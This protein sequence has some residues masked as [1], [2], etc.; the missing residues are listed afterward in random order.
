M[1]KTLEIGPNFATCVHSSQLTIHRSLFEISV[2]KNLAKYCY[3]ASKN[4]TTIM[5]GTI[6]QIYGQTKTSSLNS[7]RDFQIVVASIKDLIP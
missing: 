1:P 4:V 5:F 7:L 6:I 3:W 2:N